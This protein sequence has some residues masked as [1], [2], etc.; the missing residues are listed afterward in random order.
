MINVLLNTSIN[1]KRSDRSN[2]CTARPLYSKKYSMPIVTSRVT[3]N[4]VMFVDDDN[5]VTIDSNS[6][7]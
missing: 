6:A 5:Y 2:K 1:H 7:S 3:G 4:D